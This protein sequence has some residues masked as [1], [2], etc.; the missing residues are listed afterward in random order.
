MPN[1]YCLQM[2]CHLIQC[3]LPPKFVPYTGPSYVSFLPSSFVQSQIFSTH[4]AAASSSTW[5][6]FTY[7]RSFGMSW[8]SHPME[9]DEKIV[10]E[11]P[12]GRLAR[13][14]PSLQYVL[15]DIGL[16][17]N[18]EGKKS[19]CAEACP[20]QFKVKGLLRS[21]VPNNV[22]SPLLELLSCRGREAR[23]NTQGF[24]VDPGIPG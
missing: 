22:Y 16:V 11:T 8:S 20:I 21:P 12:K 3:E 23:G 6:H 4:A 14:S 19:A 17:E 7:L 2:P 1:S 9:Q 24:Q 13:C 5:L 15:F 18:L 10:V